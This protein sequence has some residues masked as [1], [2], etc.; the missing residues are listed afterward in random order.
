MLRVLISVAVCIYFIYLFRFTPVCQ[1]PV[2]KI[3]NESKIT[4]LAYI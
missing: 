3:I 1:P 2:F 4:S